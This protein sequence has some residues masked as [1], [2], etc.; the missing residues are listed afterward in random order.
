MKK[1]FNYILNDLRIYWKTL[2]I[3]LATFVILPIA[4]TLFM[5]WSMS[6]VNEA[7]SREIDIK[8]SI[9]NEDQGPYGNQLIKT[10]KSEPLSD[11]FHLKEDGAIQVTVPQDFSNEITTTP[12]QI[13]VKGEPKMSELELVKTFLHQWQQAVIDEEHLQMSMQDLSPESQE[14]FIQQLQAL[15]SSQRKNLIQQEA[16]QDGKK[17]P[18]I[19]K[20]L[21]SGLL[22]ALIMGLTSATVMVTKDELTGL[23]KRLRILPLSFM[24]KTL[25]EWISS[26]LVMVINVS[27][28]LFAMSFHPE[29]DASHFI[30]MVPWLIL[31]SGFCQAVGMFISSSLPKI[32]IQGIIQII[33]MFFIFTGFI[34]IGDIIGGQMKEI[35]SK[36][37]LQVFMINPLQQTM[38]GEVVANQAMIIISFVFLTVIFLTLTYIMSRRKERLK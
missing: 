12:L 36:N 31:F 38:L 27:L 2:P 18:A 34:P 26:V 24:E 5:G 21:I 22:Y 33:M 10:F 11:Y 6:G 7:T 16:T 15:S 1:L 23:I 25:F 28:I 20:Y 8:I 14:S 9:K 29:I 37:W 17:L 35:L 19:Q 32:W 4:F 13:T 30:S 3:Q